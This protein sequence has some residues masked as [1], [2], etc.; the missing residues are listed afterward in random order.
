[1]KCKDCPAFGSDYISRLCVLCHDISRG[2]CNRKEC[3]IRDELETFLKTDSR[4][5]SGYYNLPRYIPA[6]KE[7]GE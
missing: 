5:L 2:F 3:K 1:M 6:S 7:D 4:A